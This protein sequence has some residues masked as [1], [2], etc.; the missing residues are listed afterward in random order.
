M[1]RLGVAMVAAT[2][3]PANHGSPAS[4]REMSQEL[5]RR[6]HR[7]HVITYAWR[8]NIPVEGVTIH[9][10]RAVGS[11]DAIAVGPTRERPVY[12]LLLAREVVRV[13]R[14]ERLDVIHAHNYEGALAGWCGRLFTGR[15][16][17]FNSVTNMVDELPTYDFIRPRALASGMGRF[18]DRVVPRL[19]DHVTTVTEELRDLYLRDGLPPDRVTVIPPG[20]HP[21][22]FAGR[23]GDRVRRELG[24]AGAPVVMYTGVLNRFQGLEH[25]LGGFQVAL[26]EVPEARLLLM[27]NMVTPQQEAELRRQAEAL[28]IGKALLLVADRPLEDLPDFLAAADVAVLPRASSPGFPVKLLNSMSAGRAIV[29]AEGSAKAIRNGESGLVVPN[30]DA[31]AL[32]R[33]VVRLLRDPALARRLGEAARRAVGAEYDWSRIAARV[34]GIYALLL[35]V[36]PGDSGAGGPMG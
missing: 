17:L 15:P 1:K 16:L 23:T 29:A 6:G 24:L 31:E 28:G 19:A 18:L 21:E 36:P 27:G 33:A 13:I 10:T 20:V 3:F 7:V 2:S 35:A 11:P 9:R 12:D 34:E 22:W 8:Q 25:L 4:I 30:G 5:A 14:R 32:G 26:R